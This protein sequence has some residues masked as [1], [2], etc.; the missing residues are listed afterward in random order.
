M[1][2][3]KHIERYDCLS[4][5]PQVSEQRML[6][7]GRGEVDAMR[8]Y[9]TAFAVQYSQR[10][11]HERSKASEIISNWVWSPML[12]AVFRCGGS[13]ESFGGVTWQNLEREMIYM[14][15]R[16]HPRRQKKYTTSTKQYVIRHCTNIFKDRKL[17]LHH[18]RQWKKSAS[19]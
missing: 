19:M 15:R 17:H 16:G 11:L 3:G 2:K 10:L 8:S 1:K 4:V 13:A 12:L 14:S 7:T 18:P 9:L 6:P 5:F